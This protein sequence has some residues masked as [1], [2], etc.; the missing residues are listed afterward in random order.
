[1]HIA[2]ALPDFICL[3]HEDLEWIQTMDYDHAP[4]R[5]RKCHEHGHLFIYFPKK[6]QTISLKDAT[7]SD[8]EGF[9]TIPTQQRN[10]QKPHTAAKSKE[11]STS[12]NFQFLAQQLPGE[13]HTE[14]DVQPT[15]KKKH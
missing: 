5:C 12:N 8:E 4:L 1:M 10:T 15:L 13:D 3:A 6:N 7:L 2:K 11:P 9:R 14:E